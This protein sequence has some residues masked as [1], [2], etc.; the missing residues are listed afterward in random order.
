MGR[1][2]NGKERGLLN[3]EESGSPERIPMDRRKKFNSSWTI[4]RQLRITASRRTRQVR[5]RRDDERKKK[6]K[7]LKVKRRQGG[8][9]RV[10]VK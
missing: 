1:T 5:K 2:R 7:G 10:E 9:R 3:R 6:L 4:K 8:R